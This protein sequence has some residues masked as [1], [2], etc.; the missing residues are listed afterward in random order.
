[1]LD[2][3]TSE[4]G[5]A[6]TSVRRNHTRF[7]DNPIILVNYPFSRDDEPDGFLL[8]YCCCVSRQAAGIDA[9]SP[10]MYHFDHLVVLVTANQAMSVNIRIDRKGIFYN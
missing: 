6:R 10:L 2:A 9:C 1:M 5:G 8:R 3:K 7:E 4:V